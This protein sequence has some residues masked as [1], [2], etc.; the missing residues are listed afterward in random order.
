MKAKVVLGVL[1]VMGILVLSATAAQAG[2]GGQ[3]SPLTSFFS[4]VSINGDASDKVVDVEA[5][6]FGDG[7][8]A[9]KIG[10]GN[11]ACAFT[12]L[13]DPT[14]GLEIEPKTGGADEQM[15][16][17]SA[18][19]SKKISLTGQLRYDATDA[20][21]GLEE[22]IQASEIRYICGPANFTFSPP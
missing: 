6:L 1:A 16:C 3:V 7:R 13:F 17:Y 15:K 11:L 9:V 12:R 2:A 8:T 4:C 14:T 5:N 10:N 20:L 18:S 21:I 22:D 19:V